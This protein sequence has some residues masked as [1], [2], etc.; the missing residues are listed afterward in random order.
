MVEVQTG[1][2]LSVVLLKKAE[3]QI[4]VDEGVGVTV[5]VGGDVGIGVEGEPSTATSVN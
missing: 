3:R 4:G 1:A 5:G 2:P